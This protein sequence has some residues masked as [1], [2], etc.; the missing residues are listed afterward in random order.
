M[1]LVKME[2]KYTTIRLPDFLI[3]QIDKIVKNKTYGYR[4]RNEFCVYAIREILKN[5]RGEEGK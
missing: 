5:F 1:K 4:S 2:K 3:E